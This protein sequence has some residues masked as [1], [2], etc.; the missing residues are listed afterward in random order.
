MPQDPLHLLCVEPRFPGRLGGV[1]DWLVRRRGYRC[2]FFCTAA[3]SPE[4]WPEA[5]GR[6]LDVI[7]YPVGGA[8][9]GPVV[10]WT[11]FL[12]RG[13]AFA[14]GCWECLEARRPRPIELILGRTAGLGSTLF[15]PV[16]YPAA[17]L[18]NLF[19][20]FYHPHE[21]DL[22]G[23]SEPDTPPAYFYWRRAANA[24]D[25]LDLENG[26]TP[27]TPTRWQRDLYP[28]EYRDDFLV[29]H[30]GI[31]AARFV[32]PARYR[33]MPRTVAGR[34]IGPEVKLVT[35][36]ARSLDRVRG[37]DRFLALANRLLRA[38]DEVVCVALGGPVVQRGLDV[39]FFNQDYHAHLLAQT[40]PHDPQRLW[41]LDE[42]RPAVVAELLTASDLHV[43]AS[44]P[45]PVGRSLLEAMAAG[46]VVL[47]A[48]TAPVRE[49][50]THGET[51][52]LVPPVDFEAWERQALAVLRDLAGHRALGEAAAARARQHYD[53]DV[54]LPVLAEH[55]TRLAGGS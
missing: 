54:T 12:E 22:A 9:A 30:D 2:R 27:W 6:G 39:R 10:D 3:D 37:F 52:L 24:M 4:H 29:L 7:Q 19:D 5:T 34:T 20:Y 28:A 41:F 53:R 40:P 49:V 48:D 44:R 36:V 43:Y 13:L 16:Y 21:H 38:R 35:F 33:L 47:A 55:F 42:V 25:L 26:T 50:L 1:A 23:E 11:R 14:Y 32:R 45:Y 8:A 31:D 51:G 18:V 46:C 15:A 17:P